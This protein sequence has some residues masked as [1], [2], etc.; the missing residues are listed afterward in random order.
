MERLFHLVKFTEPK[1]NENAYV[2]KSPKMIKR[3][4]FIKKAYAEQN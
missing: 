4:S 1:D 2:K 3:E